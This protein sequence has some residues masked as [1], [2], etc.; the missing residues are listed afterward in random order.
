M[1]DQ[2]ALIGRRA[3]VLCLVLAP[4][5]E[6]VEALLSPLRG[7]STAAD[8]RGIAGHQGLFVVSVLVGLLATLLYVPAFL[9][10]ATRCV[11]ASPVAARLG[12][13]FAVWSMMG[14]MGVRMAQAVEL[15][16]V[17]DGLDRGDTAR[18]MD[19][20]V[21]NPIGAASL[22]LLLAGS[23]VGLV[24]LAVAGWRAG[25]PAGAGAGGRLPVPRPGPAL[26]DGDHRLA[27]GAARRPGV[28]G[29]GAGPG[30]GAGP[31]RR[32]R[33]D[34]RGARVGRVVGDV[35]PGPV[36]HRRCAHLLH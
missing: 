14:F 13:A 12:A 17:R 7:T 4:L 28:A 8:L 21:A 35:R 20:L 27:R 33:S 32:G 9:G 2:P 3:T 10:L 26:A 36:G 11:G 23:A 16:A 31:A 1:S 25:L 30:G 22:V 5:F 29:R 6:V 15:Q 24:A 34:G 18:L 19:H